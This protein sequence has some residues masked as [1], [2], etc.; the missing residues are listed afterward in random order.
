MT[1]A[2]EPTAATLIIVSGLSGSGK[3]VA[4]KTF[5][6]L[7]YYCSDNLPINLLP[8]FVRSLL[9][10]HDADAP[11]RLAVGIDVRGQSDLSQLSHW[12][13]DAQAAGL[14]AQLLFF[15]ATDEALLKRYAD[16]RR[17]HPLSQLGLSL[18]EAIAR[19]RELTAPLRRAADAVI[20]T[21]TL[22]VH[23]LRRKVVTEFAL[24]HGNKLSLLFESFAY[25][26][27][28]PAEAD[29]VF[30]ARVLPNPHWN[31]ELRPMSGREAPVREYL[32]TQP[33]VQKY[34]D[35]LI[36]FLDTW[37]P[38]LG[39]DTRSYVTVAFGCTGGKHRS[40]YLAERLARHARDQGWPEVATFHREL[41]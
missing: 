12:R 6:D 1:A 19:E 11:R 3:T 9:A 16:T 38:R 33:D 36:D 40:V 21:T 24:S 31:P 29:F 2:A 32:D 10:G 22:N 18:P 5:E 7:D 39:N 23:Q 26:R 4:L 13:E 27:G 25:K 20:D 37:L 41:D 15:D 30:D 28:V 35:Q 17:R 34:V 14:D 8:D